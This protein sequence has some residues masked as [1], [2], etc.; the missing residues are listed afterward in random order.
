MRAH[1]CPTRR[2]ALRLGICSGALALF[3]PT[4]PAPAATAMAAEPFPNGVRLLVAGTPGDG[5]DRWADTL[6]PILD[7]LLPPATR[8]LKDNAIGNDGVTG[9]N[10]FAVRATP[11]GATALLVPGA[12]ATAWLVGDPRVHFDTATWVPVM[13]GISPAVV[14]GRVPPP[15]LGPGQIPRVAATSPTG[16]ELPLLIG[17]DLLGANAQPIFGLD[18]ARKALAALAEGSIDLALLHG[19]EVP[20]RVENLAPSGAHALFTFGRL[21]ATGSWR[22]DPLLPQIP[23]FEEFAFTLLGHLPSGPLVRAHRA[24]AA[25]TMLDFALVLPQLT[26]TDMIALWRKIGEQLASAA[27]VRGLAAGCG[28]S[29]EAGPAANACTT[30]VATNAATLIALRSWLQRRYG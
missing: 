23:T 26:P 15:A 9:A 18:D 11:D 21:D 12:A 5:I 13:A 14:V 22:R 10:Q 6:V 28:L 20:Q 29:P 4:S 19:E 8:V 25:A 17:L 7:R 24:A 1:K 27:T 16:P 30:A 3:A 2:Q